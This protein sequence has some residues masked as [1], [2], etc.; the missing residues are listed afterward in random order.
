M[1]KIMDWAG[2]DLTDFFGLFQD[3]EDAWGILRERAEEETS[4]EDEYDAYLGE[5]YVEKV[6]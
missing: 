4:N 5:Y 1:F 6:A 3:A 2:N